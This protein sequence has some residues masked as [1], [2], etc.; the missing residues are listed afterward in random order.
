MAGDWIKVEHTTP[1][2]P[3]ML[4]VAAALPIPATPEDAVFARWFRLWVWADQHIGSDGFARG[5]TLE[6]LSFAAGTPGIAEAFAAEGWLK[7]TARGVKFVGWERHNGDSAKKR[8]QATERK[9]A[10]RSSQ[11]C[12]A[13]SVTKHH[14]KVGPEKR[15]EEKTKD[16]RERDAGVREADACGEGEPGHGTFADF[17]AAYP[18]KVGKDAAER[19]FASATRRAS[20]DLIVAAAREFAASPAGNAG[21]YTPHASTW[22][23]GG[24]WDDDRAEWQR[25]DQTGGPSAQSGGVPAARPGRSHREG[26][27]WDASTIVCDGDSDLDGRAG[28]APAA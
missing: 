22:L 15:R 3:E 5:M 27:D 24:R 19:A 11:E 10:S 8:A 1:I 17:W 25:G 28:S 7:Q 18:R 2:K 21:K 26:E 13:P 9:R 4:A 12:H 6:R 14:R 20:P 16:K 23:N